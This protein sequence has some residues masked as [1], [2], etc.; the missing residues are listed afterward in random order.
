MAQNKWSIETPSNEGLYWVIRE[1]GATPMIIELSKHG[2]ALF[3]NGIES[4][5]VP[6]EQWSN[7]VRPLCAAAVPPELK[8]LPE[9]A[10]G[11]RAVNDAQ[12]LALPSPVR[13]WAK[14]RSR[15]ELDRRAER[16]GGGPPEGIQTPGSGRSGACLRRVCRAFFEDKDERNSP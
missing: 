9:D 5:S 11:F 13:N 10:A 15:W 8:P 1:K 3:V 4:D 14:A 2:A 16:P 12:A 7:A 6:L